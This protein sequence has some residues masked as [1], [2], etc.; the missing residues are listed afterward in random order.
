MRSLK[1]VPQGRCLV[2]L[3]VMEDKRSCDE[4]SWPCLNS[5]EHLPLLRENTFNYVVLAGDTSQEF[6]L[7]HQFSK[8]DSWVG[9]I[10]VS[11]EFARNAKS[12]PHTKPPLSESVGIGAA[13]CI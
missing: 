3:L 10:G 11:E 12:W 4:T 13:V 5:L 7:D 1:P 6:N 9:I 8:C 2:Y